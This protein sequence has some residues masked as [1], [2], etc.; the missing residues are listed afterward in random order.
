MILTDDQV[1]QILLNNKDYQEWCKLLNI[2]LP[3]YDIDTTDRIAHFLAQVCHESGHFNTLKENLNYSAD[4]LLKVFPK[5]FPTRELAL[6]YARRPSMIANRVYANRM[7]N[8]DEASGDGW[9][10]SGLGLIQL[11]G[12]HNQ[13]AFAEHIHRSLD[14]TLKYLKTKEG[15]LHSALYFWHKNDIN[16]LINGFNDVDNISDVINIGKLTTNKIGDSIGYKHR[17]EEYT[18]IKNILK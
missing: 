12:K 15:A 4:G 2:Y 10:H 1:K 11:T 9:K 16:K 5:Y 7:G 8:G 3:K 18:R 13:T 17:F 6:Q 14:E